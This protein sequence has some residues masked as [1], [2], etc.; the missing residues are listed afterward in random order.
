MLLDRSKAGEVA[1]RTPEELAKYFEERKILFRAPEYRKLVVVS[2]I[3]SEQAR[4]VEVSDEDLK[5]AYDDRRARYVTPERSEISS[6]SCFRM[7]T[8]PRRR[9][10]HR[11]RRD[12][13]RIAAE[14]G[15]TDKDIDLGTVA[16]AGIIDRAV[17]DAAFALKEGE[18]SAPVQGR[19]GTALLRVSKIEPEK[20]RRSKKYRAELKQDIATER[21]KTADHG[22]LRQ[23]RG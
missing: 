11:Q 3:P 1:R 7:R 18:V 15:L 19:F 23:D 10:A 5:R 2:L 4:W 13:R 9:R 16:K 6:R 12:F 21:A 20:V 22:A 8:T 17:G 14:R